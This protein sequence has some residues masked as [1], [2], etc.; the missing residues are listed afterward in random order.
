MFGSH[1]VG[2]D[3]ERQAGSPGVRKDTFVIQS[4]HWIPDYIPFDLGVGREAER[5][6]D[7]S[8]V[9]LRGR[10]LKVR[11][12]RNLCEGTFSQLYLQRPSSAGYVSFFR[13]PQS[14]ISHIVDG[15]FQSEA[16]AVGR[17]QKLQGHVVIRE[18]ILLRSD[19]HDVA[20]AQNFDV[21]I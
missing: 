11:N 4:D 5:V 14:V 10:K 12:R 18:E 6:C 1:G 9:F 21:C 15:G 16:G 17:M 3:F 13:Y 20:A 2:D 19:P 8:Q 7:V